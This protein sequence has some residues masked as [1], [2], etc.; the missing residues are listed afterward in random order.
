MNLP[1]PNNP[2]IKNEVGNRYNRLTVVAF[3]GTVDGQAMWKCVCD[4]GNETVVSGKSLRRNSTKSCGCLVYSELLGKVFGRLTVQTFLVWEFH[5]RWQR[6]SLT[7]PR[8]AWLRYMTF[9]NTKMKRRR[10][11]LC[12]IRSWG[13]C[14][15]KVVNKFSQFGRYSSVFA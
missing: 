11:C 9:M 3:A 4:C 14:L 5:C 1:T 2:R 7:M 6:L 13:S 15:V 10:L 12:G 8:K